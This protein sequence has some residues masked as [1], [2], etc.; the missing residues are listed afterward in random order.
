MRLS[1]A[2][3]VHPIIGVKSSVI[4]ARILVTVVLSIEPFAA[5]L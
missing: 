5:S 3:P 1:M 2:L 4:P